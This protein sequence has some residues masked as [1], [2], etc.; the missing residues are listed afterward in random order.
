MIGQKAVAL[1][2]GTAGVSSRDV[3]LAPLYMYLNRG[4]RFRSVGNPLDPSNHEKRES[5]RETERERERD[6]G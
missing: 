6:P 2:G 1:F 4:I 5:E 3:A